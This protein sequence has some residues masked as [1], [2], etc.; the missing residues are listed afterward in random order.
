MVVPLGKAVVERVD[1]AYGRKSSAVVRGWVLFH[2][3]RV[4]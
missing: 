3:I 2:L 4:R 1:G